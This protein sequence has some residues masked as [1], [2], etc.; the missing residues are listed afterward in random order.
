MTQSR[1]R[2]WSAGLP[3][4]NS[5]LIILLTVCINLAVVFL[6]Y[7]NKPLTYWDILID[8]CICGITTSFIDVFLVQGRMKKLRAQGMLPQ[9]VPQSR[10]MAKMPKNPL[11][12]ALVFGAVFGL[13]APLLSALVIRFYTIEAFTFP[14]F[15]VWKILYSCV[16]SVKIVEF[17]ILRY[18]QPDCASES[19]AF[20]RGTEKV[21]DPLPRISTFKEWFNTVTND[22]GFN[23]LFGLLLGGTVVRDHSVIIPPTTLSGIVISALILGAIVT[24]RMAYPIAK[25]MRD[26]REAGNLPIAEKPNGRLG[27]IPTSPVKFALVL[28]VPIM[29]VCCA[30]FW[31]ILSFFGFEVL[32]FF[33]FFVIRMLFVTLLT[34]P[35]VKLAIIRYTQPELESKMGA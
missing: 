7:I 23:L 4:I 27:W 11:L 10:L 3:Y 35:V 32:D 12:L 25:N 14:R 5:I 20:Q 8:A 9:E 21:K 30:A 6:F 17:A 15:A 29:V 33:Q 2:E 28:V 13:A 24:A 34:R 31:G 16:L 19:D 26:A 22:F 18:A 1:G